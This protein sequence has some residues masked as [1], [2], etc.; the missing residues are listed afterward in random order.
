[1]KFVRNSVFALVMAAGLTATSYAHHSQSM[2][3]LNNTVT[4]TGVVTEVDWANP[5]TFYYMDVVGKD[6]KK[7]T[8]AFEANAP[9][10]LH[11]VGWSED[12]VKE[13]MTV[14]FIGNPRKDGKPTMLVQK[15]QLPDGK[16]IATKAR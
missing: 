16:M 12:T 13:G 6:G 7:V 15:V 3:D 5:H 10:A 8:W 1:M 4:V 9:N 14:S 2:F 11:S